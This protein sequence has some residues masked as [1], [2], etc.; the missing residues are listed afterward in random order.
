[1]RSMVADISRVQTGESD[2]L[3]EGRGMVVTHEQHVTLNQWASVQFDHRLIS[4]FIDWLGEQGIELNQHC[5][6]NKIGVL[7]SPSEIVDRF[8]EVDRDKLEEARR[9]L[10]DQAAERTA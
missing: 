8:L 1:M 4:E 7:L 10:L 2:P 6:S 3:M 5:A 9:A